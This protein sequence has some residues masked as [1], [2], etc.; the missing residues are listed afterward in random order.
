MTQVK[1][2]IEGMSCY[3]CAETINK[4][5]RRVKGV[6][7]ATVNFAAGN[8]IVTFNPEETNEKK[9]IAA[10]HKAGYDAKLSDDKHSTKS[11]NNEEQQHFLNFVTSAVLTLPLVLQMFANFVGVSG[12]LPVWLQALL[13]TV[14]QFVCGAR[15]YTASY[16]S[17]K[18]GS[19]NMD[20]L[21]A[22]GT[23]AAYGFSL[24]VIYFK[25]PYHLYFESSTVI[26]TLI[27]LGRWLE[28]RTKKKASFAVEKL[29]QLQPRYAVV[30]KHGLHVS[31]PI[32]NIEK[33]DI[34]VVMPGDSIPVDGEVLDGE[35]SVNES[36]LTGE[37][38]PIEKNIGSKVYAGTFNMNGQLKILASQ[39]GS[40][41]VLAHIVR[42]VETAQNSRAPI[43]KLAD[44]ISAVFVPAVIII[45]LITFFSWWLF[46]GK[47]GLALINAVAV[48]VIACPCAL[49]LATPTVIMVASGYGASLGILFKEANALEKAGKVTTLILDKTG[50]LTEGK[51]VIKTIVPLRTNEKDL[52]SIA[53]SLEHYSKHPF[54]EAI[55]TYATKHQ[56][57]IEPISEFENVPGKGVQAEKR[58]TPY[59]IGSLQMAKEKGLHLSDFVASEEESSIILIG[60]DKELLGYI[61]MQDEVRK[62]SAQAIQSLL[63]M[64]IHTIMLTGDHQKTAEQIA[65]HMQIREFYYDVLP[66]KKA[67]K[68]KDLKKENE[69]VGMVGDGINDAPALASADV[70]FAISSGSDIAI[71][72][73]DI[74]LMRNDILSV[75][76]AIQLSRETFRKIQQNLFFAFIYNCIGIPLA[77][78][79]FLNPIVA[80]AA[81]ALSSISVISN[82]LLLKQWKPSI[83]R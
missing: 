10:I 80:A 39:V 21:I 60:K 3:N 38:Y 6:S 22:L 53:A 82:A 32:E 16:H 63:K 78:L 5:L 34:I 4:E 26:I 71:E 27:L 15:F 30:E 45:S 11:K 73:A 46:A 70:G 49:G 35:S 62:N 28:S 74:A 64:G 14:V 57:P 79:G 40:E 77:A 18:A 36:M 9:L 68:V 48:L 66:E 81:M 56:I 61:L 72:S 23:T 20:L 12:E 54:A 19:A 43:Q 25:L 41:T 7:D 8:A 50:T 33:K 13:A 42:L 37:S 47:L 29:L 83:E 2:S 58:G 31:V 69:I 52:I 1:F 67:Q 17:L 24:A 65:H 51:P 76:E 55:V 59:F 44:T 75:V